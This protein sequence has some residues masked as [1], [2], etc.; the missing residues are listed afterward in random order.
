MSEDLERL[1]VEQERFPICKR[2]ACF[3]GRL[4]QEI[5]RASSPGGY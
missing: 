4:Q 3:L 1:L 2:A 5:E